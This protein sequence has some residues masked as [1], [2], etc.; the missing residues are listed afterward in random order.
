MKLPRNFTSRSF[1]VIGFSVALYVVAALVF[2]WDDVQLRLK[3]F[4]AVLLLPL[5]GLTL[6]N[7]ALRFWQW[8]IYLG[9]LGISIPFKQSLSLYFATYVMVITPGKSGE[10]FKAGILRERY[11][12]PLSKGLPVV[13]AERIY[14]FLAV[15][16]LGT[17]VNGSRRWFSLGPVR[18]QPS[19]FMKYALVILLAQY[20][21]KR[22]IVIEDETIKLST[23]NWPYL[24]LEGPMVPSLHLIISGILIIL[25]LSIRKVIIPKGKRLN[26]HFFLLGA[27]FLLLEFQNISKASLLFGSTWLVNS[28]IIS[29]I[30]I[31]ILI[32]NVVAA[33]PLAIARQIVGGSSSTR[34][35]T[36][37]KNYPRWMIERYVS[38]VCRCAFARRAA[39]RW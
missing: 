25:C 15:F 35:A 6:I 38:A 32:A 8:Q 20:V 2:G 17:K 27:A 5:A 21:A 7:Y 13:L 16:V 3:S 31:L 23:D 11:D 10:V 36:S 22:K 24:Y 34:L 12:V 1:A 4:P 18:V 37:K 9:A 26:W 39:N 30:L 19:E 29:A 14:D 28:F 33:N